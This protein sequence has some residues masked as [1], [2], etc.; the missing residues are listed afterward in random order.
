MVH[1]GDVPSVG[2]EFAPHGD[3]RNRAGTVHIDHSLGVSTI[4]DDIWNH[5]CC[6]SWAVDTNRCLRSVRRNFT[7][8][9]DDDFGT[10]RKTASWEMCDT[11]H[12][13]NKDDIWSNSRWKLFKWR[14]FVLRERFQCSRTITCISGVLALAVEIVGVLFADSA[15]LARIR[16]TSA[17][18]DDHWRI[19]TQILKYICYIVTIAIRCVFKTGVKQLLHAITTMKSMLNVCKFNWNR[20]KNNTK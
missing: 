6:K 1:V 9:P 4:K 5:R 18:G 10:G 15:V 19:R 3:R 16:C 17:R 2:E 8:S 11:R 14:I 12:L 13:G 7:C 20:D